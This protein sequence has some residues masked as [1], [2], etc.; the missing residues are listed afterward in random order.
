MGRGG[1]I[2]TRRPST[3]FLCERLALGWETPTAAAIGEDQWEVS[4]ALGASRKHQRQTKEK[5]SQCSQ[6]ELSACYSLVNGVRTKKALPSWS[7]RMTWVK[8]AWAGLSVKG[9]GS[10][11]SQEQCDTIHGSKN[12]NR[13]GWCWRMGS[14]RGEWSWKPGTWDEVECSW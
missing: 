2:S 4:W 13:K 10:L 5:G 8:K 12:S 14:L 11:P 6:W 7:R 1:S 3:P 9:T